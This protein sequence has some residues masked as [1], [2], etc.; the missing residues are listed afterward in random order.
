[1]KEHFKVED[2]FD[3]K[4]RLRYSWDNRRRN[5]IRVLTRLDR[6]NAPNGMGS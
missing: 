5:E 3:S 6:F 2:F 4:S 1:L